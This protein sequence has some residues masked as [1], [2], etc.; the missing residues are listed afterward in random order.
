MRHNLKLLFITI[1]ALI[2]ILSPAAFA[3]DKP[4]I[5]LYT[6]DVHCNIDGIKNN[7]D[8]TKISRYKQDLKQKTPYVA[9]IDAGDSVQGAPIG[10]LSSGESIINIMNSTGYDFAIPGNHEFD[11]G[12]TRFLELNKLLNCGYYS[13]NITDLTTGENLL[14]PYKIMQFGDTKIAL[15]GVTTPESL[16]SSTPAFFQDERGNFIY[17]FA[18][19]TTGKKLYD[20]V[21]QTV[22][23]VKKQGANY[24]ILVAHLGEHGITPRWSSISVARNTTGIDV[25]IDGHSHETVLADTVENAQGKNV[26]ITQTGTRLNNLGHLTIDENGK[27]SVLL[28]KKLTN[29]DS[30]VAALVNDE[31]QKFEPIL[32]Q[33]IGKS[34]ILL[35]TINPQTGNRLI[36][37]GETNLGDFVTDAYR[38]VLDTDIAICNGG[39]IRNEIPVGT[40]TYNDILNTFPFGNMCV[41]L[42]VTGQQIL[43]ALEMGASDYPQENGGFLQV[44]GLTYTIDS[45]I[46]S[47]VVTD[48]KG[49]FI[50]VDGAYRV[51]NVVVNNKPLDLNKKYTV[52]GTSYI[53]KLGGNGMTMFKDARLIQDEMMSETDV[54]IEYIQ[55]HLN[56]VIG[57]TYKNPYGQGRITIK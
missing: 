37:S 30:K 17:S 34:E 39:G 57:D 5:L 44:S 24:V 18:E 14:P 52:G 49:N 13:A 55:N 53:L 10:K 46:A 15:I 16:T 28:I 9:L 35:T 51:Q 21:Q 38:T 20:T 23:T 48:E 29:S 19:D 2:C 7:L 22:D 6:N 45:S 25:I 8:Y 50:K 27:I 43:D 54:I 32:N 1:I 47:H 3:A 4:I 36:R 56:A 41:T 31:K 42:E 33:T 12:M 11:Y 26:I 40:F